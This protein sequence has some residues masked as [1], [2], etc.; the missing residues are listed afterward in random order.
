MSY[1]IVDDEDNIISGKTMIGTGYGLE[2][3]NG[4]R[5]TLVVYGDLNGDADVNIL[6][7]ARL[8]KIIVKTTTAND[9]A[10]LASDL[11][12]DSKIDIMDL[13]KLQKLVTGQNIF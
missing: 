11:K 4:K 2:L 9:L 5:Y 13:A 10:I 3:Q 7:V 6:D 12:N 1:T 8:Q